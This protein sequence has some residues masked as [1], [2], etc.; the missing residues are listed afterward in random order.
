MNFIAVALALP[1]RL[2]SPNTGLEVFY[3]KPVDTAPGLLSEERQI[4]FQSI[5][6]FKRYASGQF[7]VG[8]FFGGAPTMQALRHGS[9]PKKV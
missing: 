3:R 8:H 5:G 7:V 4:V 9:K 6:H 2:S 1:V